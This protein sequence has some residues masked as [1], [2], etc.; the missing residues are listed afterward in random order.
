LNLRI[1]KT[2]QLENDMKLAPGDLILVP[3]NKV[4][5]V[6]RYV[7]I[8]GFGYSFNPAAF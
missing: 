1:K 3:R 6:S 8:V 5:S 2:S 7:R 4:E